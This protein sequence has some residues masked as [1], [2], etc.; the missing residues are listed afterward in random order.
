MGIEF[1]PIYLFHLIISPFLV[2]FE[3]MI[4]KYIIMEYNSSH[5]FII[6]KKEGKM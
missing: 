6:V 5:N 4:S 3:S 1:L 2:L